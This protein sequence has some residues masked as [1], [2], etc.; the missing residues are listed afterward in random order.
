MSSRSLQQLMLDHSPHMMLLVEPH[1]LRIIGANRGVALALGYR[2]EQLDGMAITEIESSLPDVFYWED[3]RNGVYQDIEA[4]EGEYR[5]ADATML[6]V[7]KSVRVIE[8]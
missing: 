5:C 2:E 6:T 4:Q 7:A 3:V 1:S 8:H